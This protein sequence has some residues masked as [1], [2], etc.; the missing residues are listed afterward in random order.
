M[1]EFCKKC[2]QKIVTGGFG[3]MLAQ[4][5]AKEFEDGWYCEKCAKLKVESARR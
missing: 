5:K 4:S 1:G 2:G 3:A